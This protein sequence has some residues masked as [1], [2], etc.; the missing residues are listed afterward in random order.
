M[1]TI[2]NGPEIAKDEFIM[3]SQATNV[4]DTQNLV[5]SKPMRQLAQPTMPKPCIPPTERT[6][7]QQSLVSAETVLRLQD[8]CRM[9]VPHAETKRIESFGTRRIYFPNLFR[10]QLKF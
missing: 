8:Q 10:V 7:R 4:C 1:G 6:W 2:A 9:P 3:N 5:L